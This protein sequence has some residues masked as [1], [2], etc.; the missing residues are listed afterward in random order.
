MP[1]MVLKHYGYDARP[2]GDLGE[3]VLYQQRTNTLTNREVLDLAAD[4][5][6]AADLPA[7][8]RDALNILKSRLDKLEGLQSQ[9]KE[10]STGQL[11]PVF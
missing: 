3:D 11:H 4:E 1:E 7:A 9:R 2:K 10:L 5:L 6:M 8:E